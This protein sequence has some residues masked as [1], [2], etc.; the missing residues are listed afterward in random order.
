MTDE[1]RATVYFR[2]HARM[3]YPIE[4]D[5]G[6]LLGVLRASENLWVLSSDARQVLRKRAYP[7]RRLW[8]TL[9]ELV[10]M[11]FVIPCDEIQASRFASPPRPVLVSDG[12][13]RRPLLSVKTG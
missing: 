7:E 3:R 1:Q 12:L 6:E 11:G 9:R 8:S 13:S 10:D 4:A 5:V 2:V